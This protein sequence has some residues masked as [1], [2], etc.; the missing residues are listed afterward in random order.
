VSGYLL[1]LLLGRNGLVGHWL[2]EHTGIQFTFHTSGAALASAVMAFP[3]FVRSVRLA[4]E[5]VP[6]RLEEAART[7]GA[8]PLRCFLGIT[9]PLA[10]PGLLMGAVLAFVRSLGEFGATMVFAGNIP[11]ET[12]TLALAVYSTLQLPGAEERVWRLAVLSI[13]LSIAAL[14]LSE[15]LARRLRRQ[16]HGREE[17]RAR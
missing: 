12:R 9:L 6:P 4:I 11:G 10:A 13:L 16:L 2:F 7:L 17:G 8:S 14:G 3:L 5:L 15:L 1:L